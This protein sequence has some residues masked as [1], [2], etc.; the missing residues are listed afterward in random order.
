MRKQYANGLRTRIQ[1]AVSPQTLEQV[2][3]NCGLSLGTVMNLA[4][5]SSSRFPEKGPHIWTLL[6]LAKGLGVDPHW[7]IFGDE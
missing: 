2:A 5:R 7:L 6:Q 3:Q 4:S 1:Q